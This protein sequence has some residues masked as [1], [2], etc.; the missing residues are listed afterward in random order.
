MRRAAFAIAPLALLAVFA[1]GCDGDDDETTPPTVPTITETATTA[2]EGD[3]A[4]GEQV[5]ASGGCGG[6]HTLSEAG[7]SGTRAP[8]LDG[9]NLEF[10]AVVTQVQNGGGGMPPFAASLSEQQIRDVAAFVVAASAS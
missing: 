6:C 7:A 5:F 4:A 3:A 1:V 8:N 2:A 10:D 9:A